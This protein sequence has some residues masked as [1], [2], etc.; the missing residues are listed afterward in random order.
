MGQS[1]KYCLIA[2]IELRRCEHAA[3][4][5]VDVRVGPGLIEHDI[6]LGTVLD[7]RIEPILVRSSQRGGAVVE[8]LALRSMDDKIHSQRVDDLVRAVSVVRVAVQNWPRGQPVQD[9]S[10]PGP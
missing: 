6:G 5:I 7:G 1:R 2:C 9:V 10:R 4:R 3:V 8:V